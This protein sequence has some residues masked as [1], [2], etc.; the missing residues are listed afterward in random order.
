[1]KNYGTA[2]LARVALSYPAIDN[3]A[4]PLL[5]AEHRS[6]FEFEGLISE[7]TGLALMQD[8]VHTLA[9]FRATAQLG[10]VLGLRGKLTWEAV[11][12]AR[13]PT[14]YDKLR[15]VFMELTGIQCIL[16]DGGLGGSSQYAEDYKWHD[17]LTRSRM[18]VE[19]T[20]I[21]TVSASYYDLTASI[22]PR[23][24]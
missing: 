14:N 23:S 5:E 8:A 7:A 16:V 3:H 22:F 12:Q 6:I 10:Q 2:E 19:A 4:Y 13:D 1:M 11:K 9:C 18:Q 17:R 20:C 21:P 24:E 15:K